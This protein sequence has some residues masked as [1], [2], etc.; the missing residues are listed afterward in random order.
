VVRSLVLSGP[1]RPTV[2]AVPAVSSSLMREQRRSESVPQVVPDVSAHRRCGPTPAI[3]LLP[4]AW[5]FDLPGRQ[6][7][8][9]YVPPVQG[10]GYQV[11]PHCRRDRD[12]I[13]LGDPLHEVAPHDKQSTQHIDPCE[14][15]DHTGRRW[16]EALELDLLI[17]HDYD[18][19]EEVGRT[20]HAEG[21][22]DFRSEE[23]ES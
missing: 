5:Q 7:P 9:E 22:T 23:Q 20:I 13:A 19:T 10:A 4:P 1:F 3:D 17:Y 2:E 8:R 14:F 16:D 18:T 15:M 11:H 12:R 21:Q 6:P